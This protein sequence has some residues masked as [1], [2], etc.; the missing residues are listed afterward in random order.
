LAE[1]CWLGWVAGCE[2]WAAL[3]GWTALAALWVGAGVA[4]GSW[5]VPNMF[6]V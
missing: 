1:G 2:G 6:Q 3:L 5:L 4:A